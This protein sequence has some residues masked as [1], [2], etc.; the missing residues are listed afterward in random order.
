MS[1]V[2]HYQILEISIG[3]SE[4]EIKKAYR[5]LA[6]KY[7]PDKNMG[8]DFFASKFI[9]V[10]QAYDTLIDARI[11]SA[12]DMKLEDYLAS[13]NQEQ[14]H[15]EKREYEQRKEKEKK[16]DEEFHFIPNKPFYS[17]RDREQQSTPQFA[18][19]LDLFYQKIADSVEFIK[20]P[21]RI[22]KLI[23]GF[24]D[25]S[26]N[27]K[28]VSRHGKVINGVLYPSAGIAIA[29]L[30]YEFA[31][32]NRFW[33]ITWFVIFGGLGVLLAMGS[34]SFA[35]KHY[36]I[37]VNGFAQLSIKEKRENANV[38]I[39]INFNQMTDLFSAETEVRRNF[40]Y[41]Y[42]G[43]FY[44][45]IDGRG[46]KALYEVDG[47]YDKKDKPENLPMEYHFL[48]EIEKYWTIYLLDNME[49]EIDRTGY[50]QFNLYDEENG[51]TPFIQLGVGYLTF[52]KEGNND[53]TY[54]FNK[55]KRMYTKGTDLCIEHE[56]FEKIFYFF[57]EGNADKIP[58]LQLSNRVFFYKAM[59]LLIGYSIK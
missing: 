58:L 55:I 21:S 36:F 40:S 10:K 8:D 24:S 9:E 11:R 27:E 42:T 43:Y 20:L 16:K 2:N 52:L 12:Y 31:D 14:R 30:I 6:I 51:T 4:S 18:P 41:E 23:C 26:K 1:I 56:N 50:L 45:F 54:R 13:L 5:K 46:G 7:H 15:R 28:P 17:F 48:R 32:P 34:N 59:E 38:D 53:V 44:H 39:E 22:G 19:E 47:S 25:L 35:Y 57:K 3:A 33:E 37:G 49:D 29:Y